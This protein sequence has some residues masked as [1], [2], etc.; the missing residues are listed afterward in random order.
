MV[1]RV[2][3][4]SSTPFAVGI[5]PVGSHGCQAR[6][7]EAEDEDVSC[8]REGLVEWGSELCLGVRSLR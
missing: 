3:G 1:E 5:V 2:R 6:E 7:L 8:I 4:L